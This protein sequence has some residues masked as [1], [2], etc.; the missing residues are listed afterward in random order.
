MTAKQW[1][2]IIKGVGPAIGGLIL[3]SIGIYGGQYAKQF[4]SPYDDIASVLCLIA[5]GVGLSVACTLIV[6]KS[7]RE[8]SP[9]S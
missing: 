6:I 4:K 9:K 3:A 1:D 2:S 7:Y 8:I 5:V